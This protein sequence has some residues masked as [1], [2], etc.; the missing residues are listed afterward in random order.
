MVQPTVSDSSVGSYNGFAEANLLDTNR[1]NSTRTRRGY[2]PD[3]MTK[4]R[5]RDDIH[6]H[7]YK[8]I[9]SAV[10]FW[11]G[12]FLCDDIRHLI[13]TGNLHLLNVYFQKTVITSKQ[14]TRYKIPK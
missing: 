11:G 14:S 13:L 10:F 4:S 9:A 5:K 3:T 6:C 8:L 12:T 7:L 1:T 2:R